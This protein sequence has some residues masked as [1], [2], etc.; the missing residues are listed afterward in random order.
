VIDEVD[1]G[2]RISGGGGLED[3]FIIP[4]EPVGDFCGEVAG[5][6]FFTIIRV[7]GEANAAGVGSHD[8]L[9]APEHAIESFESAV[10]MAWNA[11][12]IIISCELIFLVIEGELALCDAIAVATDGCAEEIRIIE[13]RFKALFSER[14]G[15]DLTITIRGLNGSDDCSVFAELNLQAMGI[16]EGEE[17]NRASVFGGSKWDCFQNERF[18]V[19]DF[20]NNPTVLASVCF[21]VI[22]DRWFGLADS[23]RF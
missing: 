19:E 13:P 11:A 10:Q 21:G 6:A 14:D 4:G 22:W 15:G 5:I 18:L 17:S 20:D 3:Q 2:G 7:V 1:R 8:R 9:A 12:R 23:S 16:S